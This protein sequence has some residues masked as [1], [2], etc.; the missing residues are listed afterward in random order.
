MPQ[1]LLIILLAILLAWEF[2]RFLKSRRFRNFI[3]RLKPP[4]SPPK[5]R[6]MKPKSEKDCPFCAAEKAAGNHR[7]VSYTHHPISWCQCK[8]QGGRKKRI[9]TQGCACPNPK[10]DYYRIID[11]QIH[12]LVGYGGHGKG[13]NIQDFYCQCCNRKFSARRN[14]VLYRLKTSSQ[15]VSLILMLLTLGVDISTLE[16]AYGISESTLRT[17][18]S[19]SGDHGQKLHQRLLTGLDLVHVQLDD[20]WAEVK[21]ARHD[22]WVRVATDVKTKLIPIIQVSDRSQKAAYQVIHELKQCLRAGCIPVFSSDGLKSYFYGLTAHF[23][24]WEIVAGKRRPVWVL[25]SA[26][27]YGQVVKHQR[28]RKLVKVERRIMCG[29]SDIYRGRL[30][31]AG[32]SGKINSSFIERLNLTIRRSISKLARRTWGLAQY[33]LELVEHIEW[34]RAYYHFSRYHESLRVISATPLKRRGKQPPRK[35]KNMTPA[36]LAPH[37]A[38]CSAGVAAGLTNRRWTVKELISYPIY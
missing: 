8:G 13:E 6:A 18:L 35:Y 29:D 15:V 28:R 17:W 24:K 33:P 2:N 21:H 34:W 12:A 22:T 10:C 25:L 23:G 32:L 38:W 37:C 4:T 26:L 31:A 16:E 19:R 20:L 30:K 14:T 36:T 11:E 7:V 9:S 27:V 3:A 5:P 1:D